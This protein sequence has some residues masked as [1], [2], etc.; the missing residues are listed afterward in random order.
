MWFRVTILCLV[1][2]NFPRK[3]IT[4]NTRKYSYALKWPGLI[5]PWSF[6]VCQ[7]SPCPHSQPYIPALLPTCQPIYSSP[8]ATTHILINGN[9]PHTDKGFPDVPC[10]ALFLSF[11]LQR[12]TEWYRDRGKES[13]IMKRKRRIRWGRTPHTL[14]SL[15]SPPQKTG[16]SGCPLEEHKHWG[17]GKFSLDIP[18]LLK[19]HITG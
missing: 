15:I 10:W 11:R 1:T 14:P 3:P 5:R 18:V 4:H 7:F 13:A 8:Q 6:P 12:W 9:S 2:L 19:S 17:L 16:R